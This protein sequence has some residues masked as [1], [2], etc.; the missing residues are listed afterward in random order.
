M[1]TIDKNTDNTIK[2]NIRDPL[3]EIIRD[4]TGQESIHLIFVNQKH[5]DD[6]ILQ[7]DNY[8]YERAYIKAYQEG[9]DEGKSTACKFIEEMIKTVRAS[10]GV[11]LP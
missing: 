5:L 9:Y 7:K 10:L 6:W 1:D 3:Q 8:F 2:L 4:A 11:K